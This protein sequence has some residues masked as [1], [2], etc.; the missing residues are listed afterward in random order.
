MASIK[1][2]DWVTTVQT[3]WFALAAFLTFLAASGIA[4]PD[5]LVDIISEQVWNA[6]IGAVS[7]VVA[8]FQLIRGFISNSANAEVKVLS[9]GA[10][11]AYLNPFKLRA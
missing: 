2:P 7:S 11:I 6:L 5:A 10:K 4:V 3:V 8:F 9:S 1:F